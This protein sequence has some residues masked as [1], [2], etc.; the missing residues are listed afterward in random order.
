MIARRC[1]E[2]GTENHGA[3]SWTRGLCSRCYGRNHY[4]GTL[5]RYSRHKLANPETPCQR[6]GVLT[7]ED[8]C[9]DCRD[10]ESRIEEI[11]PLEGQ[12]IRHNLVHRFYAA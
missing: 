3:K 4:A 6:C 8:E 7:R 11:D 9:R 2:C 1:A 12:W 5:D 10:I